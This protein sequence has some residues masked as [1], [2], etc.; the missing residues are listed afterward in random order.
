[1]KKGFLKQRGY[2]PELLKE[3]VE[4]E[5]KTSG[6]DSI[7]SLKYPYSTSKQPRP[8]PEPEKR[9]GRFQR[10]K[11]R[12]KSQREQEQQVQKD[13]QIRK[14]NYLRYFTLIL[15]IIILLWSILVSYQNY[16]ALT[17]HEDTL[18]KTGYELLKEICTHDELKS[19]FDY[20]SNSWDVNKFLKLSSED[21][22]QDLTTELNGVKFLIEVHDLSP[23]PIK[24]NRTTQNGLAWSTSSN[25]L[26]FN[27][28]ED[29]FTIS[30]LMNIFV[31][32]EEV[33]LVKV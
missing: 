24:Y 28:P 11:E 22:I 33:H 8:E 5:I 15:G 27:A 1:M 21:L 2:Q 18:E 7:K 3:T 10:M 17:E 14:M 32:S 9:M 4:S 19:D 23:Y 31:T 30:M 29:S 12:R 25:V 16:L 6:E 26:A 13:L 20:G